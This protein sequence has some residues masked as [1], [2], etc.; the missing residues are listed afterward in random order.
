MSLEIRKD[1]DRVNFRIADQSFCGGVGLAAELRRSLRASVGTPIPQTDELRIRALP[2]PFRMQRRYVSS[3]EERN[4][5]CFH[6][7]APDRHYPANRVF[8]EPE[9]SQALGFQ[10]FW[11]VV[12]RV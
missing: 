5:C 11:L 2:D 4:S 7:S 10:V 12:Q 6:Q 9:F 8:Q 3:T 1:T